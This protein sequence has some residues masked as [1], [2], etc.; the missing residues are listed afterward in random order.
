MIALLRLVKPYWIR[1]LGIIASSLVVSGSTAAMAGAIKYYID[2][3]LIKGDAFFMA[4]LPFAFVGLF[5]AKG[6]FMF[7]QTYLSRATGLKIIRDIR[8]RLYNHIVSMPLGFFHKNPSGSLISRLLNDAQNL[9][10]NLIDIAK[11]VFVEG[12]TVIGLLSVAF[13]R[14][15]DLAL[16][17]V[18]VLPVSFYGVRRLVKR[19]KSVAR[20]SQT[21]ISNLTDVMTE[22]FGAMKIVKAFLLEGERK[23]AFEDENRNHYRL[24]MKSGRLSA[25]VSLLMDVVAGAGIGFIIWYGGWLASHGQMT[26]GDFTSYIAATMLVFTPMKRLAEVQAKI[27]QAMAAY[28]RIIGVLDQPPERFGT[29]EL[30]RIR[31][32][33]EF[34]NVRLR[35]DGVENDALCGVSLSV[36]YGEMI[37]FVGQSGA[38]KTSLVDLIPRFFRP[39]SGRILIDGQDT[40]EATLSSLR[41]QIGLVSQEIILFDDTVANNIAMG[42]PGASRDEIILAAK[43][44][45]A[46]DFIGELP[47][48][49][50]TRIGERGVMLSGG[51]RQRISIA[52]ALLKNPP[53]L[54]L[55]E[56]TSALD[57]ASEIAVQSALETLM[58]NRTTFVIAHRLSTVRR[59]DRIVVMERG[60]IVESGT[61]D[62]LIARGGAY[63]GLHRVQL[64]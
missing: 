45:N 53:I 30:P 15:W 1:V 51:Q 48:G 23:S 61:H 31:E 21:R 12:F 56:A 43:S 33:I 24:E 40:A 46:H 58:E 6:V 8:T 10:G 42:R 17:T 63:A 29:I 3:V 22:T 16:I 4:V 49:Y 28:E 55:D 19:I 59:A 64:R 18:V 20:G 52:R 5:I 14:R 26:P 11:G 50:E 27:Y 2:D 13:W 7:F 39:T 36:R 47:G 62:E 35:Y 41:L 38:G 32:R 54:I 57:T 34:D 25:F 60:K 44:A 9:Q 37:A